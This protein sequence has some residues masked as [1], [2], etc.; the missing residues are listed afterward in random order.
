MDET[1][2][3]DVAIVGYGPTSQLL[4]LLLGRQGHSVLV[5]ERWPDLYPLPR[6]VVF[7]HEI[8]RLLQS[9]G[10][11]EDVLPIAEPPDAYEWRNA[12]GETLLKFEWQGNGLSGW[13]ESSM[14]SQPELERV[15]DRHVKS[16]PNV[17]VLQGH[18]VM[19][20]VQEADGVVAWATPVRHG[21]GGRR[22]TGGA[23]PF[24]CR[25]LVGADG[26]NSIVRQSIGIEMLDQGF[27]FDWLVVDI[28]PHQKRQWVPSTW[29]LCDPARPT[30]IVPSGPGR[31]RWEFMLLPG[32]DSA[33]MGRAERAWE[34]LAPWDITPANAELERHVVYRFKGQWADPWRNRRVFLAGDAAHLMP[35]FA[36]Q[37]MCSGMRDAAAIAWRLGG[38]LDGRLGEAVLESYGPERLGHVQEMIQ[39]SIGLG[40]V[41]CI[42]DP[43]AAA[44]R[45]RQM[46]A[47]RA[48]PGYQPP[49]TPK[50][51]LGPGM[52]CV[53]DPAAGRLTPQGQVAW[54][55]R[56]GLFDDV[57]GRGFA[58]IA[59]DA[60]W[61]AELT[62]A[63]REGLAALGVILQAIGPQA[64]E[65][66]DGVYGAYFAA[67]QCHAYLARP[68]FYCYGTAADAQ[69]LNALVTG[70][71][72]EPGVALEEGRSRT[73]VTAAARAAAL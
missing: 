41:I 64:A 31:R 11:M 32:E 27:V 34:L 73:P 54:Q 5:L 24:R 46:L 45:D 56:R 42:A 15:L 53:D 35:P 2:V 3:F 63:N 26:A 13:P 7:D 40:K 23:R 8:A 20:I 68:D 1:R 61:F 70:W 28:K 72:Q 50:P 43:A 6:A 4:A 51:R 71:L 29:Q 12:A 37:G 65:D 10:V 55:G 38:V 66:L 36:G 18:E 48:A 69:T 30:T 47:A 57:V 60:R 19:R 22:A 58:L 52:F 17:L 21:E 25:Y 67:Q 39:F 33:A 16:L 44:E 59:D 49:Q 14:F 62:P 9:C